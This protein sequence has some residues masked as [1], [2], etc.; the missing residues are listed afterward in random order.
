MQMV[1][2]RYDICHIRFCGIS[3][4]FALAIRYTECTKRTKG[5]ISNDFD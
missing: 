4:P 3:L 2:R 5:R 1:L